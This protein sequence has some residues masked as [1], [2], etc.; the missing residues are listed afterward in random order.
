M[1]KMISMCGLECHECGARI[2]T[3][4]NDDAKRAETAAE[5][6]KQFGAVIEIKD[7]NCLGCI[8]DV[9]PIFSHCRVCE[10]RLCGKKRNLANCA[11]CTDYPCDRLETFFKMVP[12]N[13]TRLDALRAGL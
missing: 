6:A 13:R 3:L 1:D 4:T 2:A 12:A 8:S 10:I 5:W 11:A 9:E 7:I